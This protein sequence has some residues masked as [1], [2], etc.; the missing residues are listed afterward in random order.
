MKAVI[1][2]ELIGKSEHHHE[3]GLP[4]LPYARGTLVH[5]HVLCW[6]FLYRALALITF[7]VHEERVNLQKRGVEPLQ[8]FGRQ[9]KAK[10]QLQIERRLKPKP[11]VSI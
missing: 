1:H 11:S 4:I 8:G 3:Q 10:E 7:V 2:N 9:K 5:R 6:D